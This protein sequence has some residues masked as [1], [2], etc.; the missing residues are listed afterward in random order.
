ME[1]LVL[2]SWRFTGGGESSL[3]T[4]EEAQPMGVFPIL[5][6]TVCDATLRLCES[7]HD[8]CESDGAAG[9]AKAAEVTERPRFMRQVDVCA[10]YF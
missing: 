2:V 6:P 3:E 7:R 1:T 10:F 4:E 9:L 8:I 5:D